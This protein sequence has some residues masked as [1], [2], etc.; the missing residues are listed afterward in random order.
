MQPSTLFHEFSHIID[1]RLAWDSAIRE[2]AL[3]SEETWLALQPDGFRYA[4]S[5]LTIP[6][7]VLRYIDS[8]YFITEYALCYP[9]EDRAVLME[10]AMENYYWDFEPG[11]GRRTKMEFYAAC[12]RDCFDTTGWPESVCWEQ[13]LQLSENYPVGVG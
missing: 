12:I 3:Y 9:T 6:E 4:M 11:S 5:Y 8:G 1:A 13:V 7:D 10:S 2:D